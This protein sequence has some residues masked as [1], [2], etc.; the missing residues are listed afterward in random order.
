MYS[1]CALFYALYYNSRYI[2]SCA[3]STLR[4]EAH[5]T[6]QVRAWCDIERYQQRVFCVC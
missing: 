3:L 2:I 1:F 4:L 5:L 6:S